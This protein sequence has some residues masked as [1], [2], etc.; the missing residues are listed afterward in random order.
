MTLWRFFGSCNAFFSGSL[1]NPK[2]I[3]FS[4]VLIPPD[5]RD[6][7]AYQLL[8]NVRSLER[9]FGILWHIAIEQAIHD[10]EFGGDDIAS[11]AFAPF[12]QLFPPR[13]SHLNLKLLLPSDPHGMYPYVP[14]LTNFCS[15]LLGSPYM[16]YRVFQKEWQ[17]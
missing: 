12:P 1:C 9:A 5:I 13:F 14:Q 3:F 16:V 8:S 4:V 10:E 17:K 2:S 7:P 6:V 15:G 11:S